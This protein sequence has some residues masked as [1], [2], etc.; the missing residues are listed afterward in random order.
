[1]RV[2]CAFPAFDLPF[3]PELLP[4]AWARFLNLAGSGQ[5]LR[6]A[7]QLFYVASDHLFDIEK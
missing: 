1:M 3:E 7:T 2:L 5:F 4:F 6:E